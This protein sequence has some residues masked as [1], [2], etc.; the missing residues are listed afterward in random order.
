MIIAPIINEANSPI[1]VVNQ[2]RKNGNYATIFNSAA[3][4]NM[5]IEKR[6]E[7]KK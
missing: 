4:V 3:I 6:I 2:V 1:P 7:K 5:E